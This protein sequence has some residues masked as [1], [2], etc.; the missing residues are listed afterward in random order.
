[1]THCF[2]LET[3]LALR[4]LDKVLPI[5]RASCLLHAH[6][7]WWLCSPLSNP[8]SSSLDSRDTAAP[9]QR[10]PTM[11]FCKFHGF[12]VSSCSRSTLPFV[13][14]L[15]LSCGFSLLSS[16]ALTFHDLPGLRHLF[17]ELRNLHS[18]SSPLNR[19]LTLHLNTLNVHS[20]REL[21]LRQNQSHLI[22][23]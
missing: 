20:R 23:Q 7:P 15:W 22:V 16:C 18:P 19:L 17:K 13:S 5:E 21:L 1:M 4:H 6:L 3:K 2:S 12:G 14:C 10:A 8:S 9:P 11:P